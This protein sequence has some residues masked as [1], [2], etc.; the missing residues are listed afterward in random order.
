M[1]LASVYLCLEWWWNGW[2]PNCK[3]P[4]KTQT[5]EPFVLTQ[6]PETIKDT[7]ISALCS[8]TAWRNHQR[9]RYLSP[10]YWQGSQQPP[11]TQTSQPSVVTRQPATTKDA[12]ISAL[13]WHG[14]Q[15]PSKTQ[16]SKPSVLTRQPATTKDTDISALY[17]HGSQKPPKTQTS[18]PFV[19]TRQPETIK[20]T[21]ISALSTDTAARN[22]QRHRHL[23]PLYWHGSSN[24]QRHRHL[25]PLYWHGM[26]K[27]PKT[28]TSKPSVL[29]RQPETIK[30]TYISAL[31]WHSSQKPSK[32]Q[33]SKPSILTRQ[34]ET[35]KYTDISAFCTDTA[36]RN[37]QRHR[38]LSPL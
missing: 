18:Q 21:D 36:A 11:K 3:K 6:Q 14:S 19:L 25:S 4:P 27:P 35:I 38:H 13:Y 32:T 30:D 10:L 16:T 1:I 28:Q 7:D 12:D 22:H 31:Y 33:T 8:D 26:Q 2:L 15:K 9:H 34:P 20:D 5:S 24:H 29:T 37:Q 23:S 17:W